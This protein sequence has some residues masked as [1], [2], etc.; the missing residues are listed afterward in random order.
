VLDAARRRR[1]LLRTLAERREQQNQTQTAVAAAMATSQSFVARLESTAA[2][3]R[4][5]TVE[6]YAGS[7]GY[8]VQYHV[9]PLDQSAD[10]PTVVV[11]ESSSVSMRLTCGS[12]R[13][14]GDDDR[15]WGRWCASG[16]AATSGVAP[17]GARRRVRY[18]GSV[19]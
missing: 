3:A 5:S 2:D 7:L 6:R 9:V 15:T 16:D 4:V 1:E 18:A 11:H 10:E 12:V 14:L 19:R 13:G 8:V 17:G